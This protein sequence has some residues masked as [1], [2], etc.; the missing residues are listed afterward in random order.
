PA[1]VGLLLWLPYLS[2][3]GVSAILCSFFGVFP[4]R[5]VRGP[6]AW[7]ALWT[8]MAVALAW[9]ARYVLALLGTPSEVHPPTATLQAV[10]PLTALSVMVS[11]P[12]LVRGYRHL[13]SPLDRLR[14]RVVV[15]GSLS[16]FMVGLPIVLAYW[17]D[18]HLQLTSS[19]FTS[20]LVMAGTLWLL[21]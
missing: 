9:H 2:A 14:T 15:L 5:Q 1:P 13:A 4:V 10:L 16:A 11:L 17:S 8:P 19:L 20:P 7:V 3:V 12:R 6:L 18:P 21:V